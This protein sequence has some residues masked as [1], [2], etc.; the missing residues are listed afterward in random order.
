[1]QTDF[2]DTHERNIRRFERLLDEE[3]EPAGRRVLER[4]IAEERTLLRSVP[5]RWGAPPTD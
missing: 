4:L 5:F 3:R 1:M 2:P